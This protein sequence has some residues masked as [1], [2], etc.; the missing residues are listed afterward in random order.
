MAVRIQTNNPAGLLATITNA[1]ASTSTTPPTWRSD[2]YKELT[3]KPSEW[4]SE[5]WF[6]AITP[7]SGDTELVF[8]FRTYAAKTKKNSNIYPYYHGRFVEML[9]SHFKSGIDS[10]VVTP[11]SISIDVIADD[12]PT[13]K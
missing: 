12:K 11:T 6:A 1:F 9:I 3:H 8:S 2:T 7:R 4:D 13:D 5:G 10:I